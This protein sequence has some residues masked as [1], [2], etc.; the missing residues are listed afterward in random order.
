MIPVIF[1]LN[2]FQDS[3]FAINVFFNFGFI[4]KEKLKNNTNKATIVTPRIHLV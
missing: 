2:L 3:V 1:S 4:N